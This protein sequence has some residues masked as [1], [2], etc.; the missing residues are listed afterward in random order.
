M[1]LV[2]EVIPALMIALTLHSCVNAVSWA[3][4]GELLITSGDDTKCV[5]SKNLKFSTQ[6]ADLDIFFVI[7]Q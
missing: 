2:L 3:Q 6:M 5:C 1:D 7:S 4:G